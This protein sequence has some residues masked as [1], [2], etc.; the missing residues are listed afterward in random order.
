MK[1]KVLYF[2][3]LKDKLNK[4]FEYVEVENNSTLKDLKD[5]IIEKYPFYRDLI[6]SCMIAVNEKYVDQ[7]FP[8]K[9][10][11]VVAFITP[12]GGG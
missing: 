1:V 9:E 3:S 11:D 4:N 12:V 5:I 6:N 2:A 8:L 10:N 7:D